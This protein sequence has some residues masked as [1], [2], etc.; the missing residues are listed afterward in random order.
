[1]AV[2]GPALEPVLVR[3]AHDHDP[4]VTAVP[5]IDLGTVE[6]R[7]PPAEAAARW[8]D[9]GIR[10]V[11]LT[12]PVSLAVDGGGTN[13]GTRADTGTRADVAAASRDA[14][15]RLV[16]VRELTSHGIAVDWRL[17]LPAGGGADWRVFCHL[18][19][20]TGLS[21][22]AE[23]DEDPLDTWRRSYYIDKCTFRRGPGFVQVRDR[24][25]S[26]LNLLTVDDPAYLAV[27]AQVMDGAPVS[28][29]DLDVARDFAAEGLVVQVGTMLVWLPYR[30][31]RWPLPSMII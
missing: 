10:H 28:D 3:L 1:M 30:L 17:L 15:R 26:R 21:A 5:G 6:L 27:L 2:A 4:V 24:R 16:L 9:E 13:A 12:E 20:P 7:E 22:V 18:Y 31:R 19:P 29:V 14:V 11:T 8:F 23:G 25:S